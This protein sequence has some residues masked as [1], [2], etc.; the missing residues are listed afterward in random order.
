M[1]ITLFDNPELR[2][3]LLPFTFTR[4]VADLRVGILTITEKWR[5]LS[6]GMIS[7]LT[8]DYL[9]QKY[10]QHTAAEP[11]FYINGAVCPTPELLQQ[12]QQ[13]PVGQSLVHE[14]MLVALHADS[15]E[16][17]SVDELYQHTT[18]KNS[19]SLNT[20]VQVV[21]QPWNIFQ[22][23]GDQIK[24]DFALITKGRES[25]PILD[26]HTIVYNPENV[27]LEEGAKIRAAIL[28]AEN[29]PIYIGRNA[30]VHEGAIIR[31]PFGL[32]E[33]S[34]VNI[35]G[36]MRGDISIGPFCKVGGEVNNSVFFGYSNK[37]H[38]GFLGNSVVGEWCNF[39]ADT[40]ASNLKNNYAPIKIWS[41]AQ[42]KQIDTGL[43]FCGLL[44]ADHVKCG[45]NTMFNTGTVVG[46]GANIFGAG[47]PPSFIPSF[48]W[49]GADET[50]TFRLPK[51]FEIA[52]AVLGRRSLKLT[53]A[54]R[55][56][57]AHIFETTQA[58]RPWDA[59]PAGLV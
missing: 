24:A 38:E 23:N 39:G 35:G 59:V 50:V 27:F 58:D 52:N 15:S 7:Y 14:G 32:G 20:P 25:Q 9:Q 54:E 43:Q 16:F 30:E 1:N 44:M 37:G 12:I 40:N 13:L 34:H 57:F 56:I 6:E 41:Q 31:G 10:Q 47:F 18:T 36:K 5:I 4:P 8:Q 53:E 26:K 42:G 29:G 2:A 46:V 33:E 11:K 21:R 22:L 48:S 17:R 49:G 3:N 55:K 51:F 28:N 19:E 45:I